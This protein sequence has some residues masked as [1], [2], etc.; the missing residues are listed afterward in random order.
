MKNWN[1]VEWGEDAPGLKIL[2][3]G[4]PLDEEGARLLGWEKIPID[5]MGDP[6]ELEGIAFDRPRFLA[7]VSTCESTSLD[8]TATSYSYAELT[9][10]E[11]G[12]IAAWAVAACKKQAVEEFRLRMTEK[13]ADFLK[14]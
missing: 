1:F 2:Q 5:D 11:V 6:E 7:V 4:V 3:A 13:F 9:D 14:D 10:E 8:D 12:A